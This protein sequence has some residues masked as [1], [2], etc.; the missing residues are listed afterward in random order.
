MI[1]TAGL[2]FVMRPLTLPVHWLRFLYDLLYPED[3]PTVQEFIGYCLIPSD[4]AHVR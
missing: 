1:P 3:I 2:L 4:N